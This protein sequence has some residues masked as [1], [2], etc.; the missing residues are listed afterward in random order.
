MIPGQKDIFLEMM[1]H[2]KERHPTEFHPSGCA[3]F[4]GSS[5]VNIKVCPA[6]VVGKC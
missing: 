5:L 3:C 1:T 4:P 2:E 6:C